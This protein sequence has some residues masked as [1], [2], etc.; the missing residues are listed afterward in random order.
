MDFQEILAF[1]AL[2]ALGFLI[3][4]S[5]L[6]KNLM[7]IAEMEIVVVVNPISNTKFFQSIFSY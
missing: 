3:K 2:I 5:F 7:E 1:S 4:N 6:K